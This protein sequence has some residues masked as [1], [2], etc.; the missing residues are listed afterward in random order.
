MISALVTAGINGGTALILG[1][2]LEI[3]HTLAQMGAWGTL[4]ADFLG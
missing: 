3:A 2:R 1:A 4:A